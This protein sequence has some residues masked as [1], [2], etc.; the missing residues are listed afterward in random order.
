MVVLIGLATVVAG[1]IGITAFSHMDQ[2]S[3]TS[4]HLTTDNSVP[5]P[6]LLRDQHKVSG[7]VTTTAFTTAKGD[8]LFVGLAQDYDSGSAPTVTAAAGP[9]SWSALTH[10]GSSGN[11]AFWVYEAVASSASTINQVTLEASDTFVM[12]YL[13]VDFSGSQGFD[14]SVTIPSTNFYNNATPQETFSS[15]SIAYDFAFVSTDGATGTGLSLTPFTGQS[16]FVSSPSPSY[17]VSMVYGFYQGQQTIGGTLSSSES[18]Y[19]ATGAVD[20]YNVSVIQ[21][22]KNYNGNLTISSFSASAGDILY[23]AVTQNYNAG[24]TPIISGSPSLAWVT[25]T[26]GGS[27]GSAAQ[28]VFDFTVGS[29][30]LSG[31]SFHVRASDD[32]LFGYLLV[33]MKYFSGIDSNSHPT[34]SYSS[35]ST[36]SGS[37]TTSSAGVVFSFIG[38]I[39]SVGTNTLTPDSGMTVINPDPSASY[40]IAM[41]YVYAASGSQTVGGTLTTAVSGWVSTDAVD[42]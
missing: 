21:T 24:G 30:G 9:L 10:G 40:A 28:W 23:L 17:A 11:C 7:S 5:S 27:T 38:T 41:I 37:T 22:G 34:S 42:G 13:L 36:P 35:S 18:G 15:E 4:S 33:D 32:L 39:N 1:S 2:L 25:R 8:V 29:G 3:G 19:V 20:F 12:G 31:Y 6:T 26:S 14:P 16:V